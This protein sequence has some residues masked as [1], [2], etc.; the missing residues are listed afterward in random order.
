MTERADQ[1]LLQQQ[2]SPKPS[3]SDPDSISFLLRVSPPNIYRLSCFLNSEKEEKGNDRSVVSVTAS[4]MKAGGCNNYPD[5]YSDGE[6]GEPGLI[7][8]SCLVPEIQ[9]RRQRG[10]AAGLMDPSPG[11]GVFRHHVCHGKKIYIPTVN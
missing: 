8:H 5:R 7:F 6:K 11:M 2:A 1:L 9:L 3:P 10:P 4:T